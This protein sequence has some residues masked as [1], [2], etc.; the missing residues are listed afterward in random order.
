M[1]N[2]LREACDGG[3]LKEVESLIKEGVDVDFQDD[4][5]DTALMIASHHGCNEICKFLIDNGA[6]INIQN[7]Q[8]DTALIYSSYCKHLDTCKLLLDSGADV[9]HEN[10]HGETALD[11]AI[12]ENYENIADLL[13]SYKRKNGSFFVS[14][15]R[16]IKILGVDFGEEPRLPDDRKLF[17]IKWLPS[18]WIPV[19]SDEGNNFIKDNDGIERDSTSLVEKQYYVDFNKVKI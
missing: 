15:G 11:T 16:D 1:S 9:T 17:T 18:D 14:G 2:E 6:N 8:G 7:E 12:S 4:Y 19:D 13:K 3:Y 5:G 10:N